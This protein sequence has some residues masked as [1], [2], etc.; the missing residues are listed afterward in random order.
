MKKNVKQ[1]LM[2]PG[3]T[4]VSPDVLLAS[5]KPM[6]NHRGKAFGE[7][8]NKIISSVQ[9][10]LKTK[11][12]VFMLTSSG[13]GALEACAANI[14]TPGDKVLVASIGNFGERFAKICA[15]NGAEVEKLSFDKGTAVDVKKLKAALDKDTKK[16]IKAVFFQQNETSTGVL[17]DVKSI[18]KV[19]K[20]HG[21]LTVVDAVSGF[22]AADLET[23]AW[24]LDMVA[25]G[26]QKAFM[27]A[28]GLAFVSV[29]KKAWEVIE[30]A[31]T[32]AFYFNLLTARDFAKKGQ[33]PW[34]PAVST[35]FSMLEALRILEEE[36]IESIFAR[37]ERLKRAV[38]A[39]VRALGFKLLADDDKIASPAVTS[40]VPDIDAEKVRSQMLKEYDVVLA[41]GQSDL[42]GKIFRIGHLGF[43][44]PKE[45]LAT[46]ACLE[47]ALNDLGR[48]TE[49]GVSVKAVQEALQE[50]VKVA[51]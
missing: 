27:V 1:L 11:N 33:T 26:S 6:I 42:K 8:F 40:V 41:G 9:K 16:E 20:E 43:C 48:K 3:P 21:A 39:G 14:I 31:K 32:H 44:D 38:R 46:F 24:G 36:G 4:N 45:I 13:T 18:A 2:I 17:N 49:L 37:H 50:K 47:M 22:L 51:A 19:V 7:V 15:A 25:S 30:K 34:T 23:D 35:A 12:D 10:F 29:S 28:P 5:A